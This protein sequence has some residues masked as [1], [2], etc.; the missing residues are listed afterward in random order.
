MTKRKKLADEKRG[1]STRTHMVFPVAFCSPHVVCCLL[2]AVL[3]I[4]RKKY[5][6]RGRKCIRMGWYLTCYFYKGPYDSAS[7]DMRTQ[8]GSTAETCVMV[9]SKIIQGSDTSNSP[10]HCEYT[11]SVQK[12]C[13]L[14]L[15]LCSRV[16]SLCPPYAVCCMSCA[17]LH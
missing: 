17:I 7:M 8:S 4:K 5:C 6:S 16:E 3:A 10:K 13:H 2:S 14:P 1:Y 11:P 15:P 12:W 9:G